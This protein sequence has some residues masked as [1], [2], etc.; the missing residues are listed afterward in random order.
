MRLLFSFKRTLL[1]KASLIDR[2]GLPTASSP[3]G[4]T[5]NFY[6]DNR[7]GETIIKLCKEEVG[8]L[9]NA[10]SDQFLREIVAPNVL[11]L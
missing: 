6:M 10:K 11:S 8:P 9:S 7:F 5:N 4:R 2:H 1:N 3:S